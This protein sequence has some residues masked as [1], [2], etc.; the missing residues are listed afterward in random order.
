MTFTLQSKGLLMRMSIADV[1]SNHSRQILH[2]NACSEK[3]SWKNFAQFVTG[4]LRYA[5]K[6]VFTHMS[7][8][9]VCH[10]ILAWYMSR[11][12]T[13]PIQW[14]VRPSKTQIS[15]GIRPVWSE[16]SLGTLAILLVLSWG[17]SHRLCAMF[18]AFP[19]PSSPF[20]EAL[21]D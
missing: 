13:K 8:T 14:P 11:L 7:H 9:L 20:K 12:M 5:S 10:I 3:S 17:G 18:V 4:C 19:G 16:F 2:D 1:H 6:V 21:T 15:L